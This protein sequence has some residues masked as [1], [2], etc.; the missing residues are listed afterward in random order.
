M[1][2]LVGMEKDY[3]EKGYILMHLQ[4][5]SYADET[6]IREEIRAARSEIQSPS[7]LFRLARLLLKVNERSFAEDFFSQLVD[8]DLFI[9]DTKRQASLS[10]ALELLALI[11]FQSENF[12]RASE[13]FLL[14]L[15]AYHRILPVNSSDLY[16]TYRDL[17]ESFYRSAE[18][19]L[20]IDYFQRALD[21]QIHSNSPNLL[22]SA[23][24][25]FKSGL[26]YCE[27]RR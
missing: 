10:Q 9:D 24:C 8:E 14:G 6:N 16:P 22:F 2:K 11:H 3:E 19:Q 13:L 18:Y 27:T 17:G 7:P 26:A 12:K 5:V 4:F 1:T 23:F 25:C 20:A 21:T 15:K